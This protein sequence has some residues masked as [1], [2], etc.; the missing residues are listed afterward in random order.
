[1]RVKRG[2]VGADKTYRKKKLQDGIGLLLL[3]AHNPL[4]EALLHK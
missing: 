2:N 4:G 3:E 1:V